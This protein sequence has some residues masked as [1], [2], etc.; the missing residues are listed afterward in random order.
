MKQII[1]IFFNYYNKGSTKQI[2]FESALSA[3]LL[4]VFMNVFSI[5]NFLNLVA[6]TDLMK[7][8]SIVKQYL[9]MSG[10]FILPGYL[11]LSMLFK[12]I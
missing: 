11:I 10:C 7:D 9:V 5:V 2:A 4:L 8:Q 6:I 3:C 1:Y 12:K